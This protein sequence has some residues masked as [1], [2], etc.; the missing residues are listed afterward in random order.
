MSIQELT[1]QNFDL[2][3][4]SHALLVIDFW[5]EW[6]G[7]CKTFSKVMSVVAKEYPDVVF[8]SVD[9]EKE[10][11]LSE[12]F[13]V[14]SV[15]FVMIIKDRTVIYADSGALSAATLRELLTQAKAL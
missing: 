6:C 11:E 1:H 8:A 10:K 2:I 15:P 9:I 3:L 13:A 7:P 5:A 4:E 14:R 12:E